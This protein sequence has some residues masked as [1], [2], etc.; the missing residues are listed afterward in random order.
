MRARW[1]THASRSCWRPSTPWAA[2]GW[3]ACIGV[4]LGHVLHF[5]QDGASGCLCARGVPPHVILP[6]T[7]YHI[8]MSIPCHREGLKPCSWSRG[9]QVTADHGNADDMVQRAKKTNAPL[10]NEKGELQLLTSHTL[11]RPAPGDAPRLCPGSCLPASFLAM[12][13]S[14]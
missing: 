3:C 8:E 7:A 5:E 10:R 2:A 12:V 1:W 11:V 13:C 14:Y 6:H 9:V 4:I